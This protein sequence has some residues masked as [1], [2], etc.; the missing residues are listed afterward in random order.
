MPSAP[1]PSSG[2]VR[3]AKL[4]GIF[5][6]DVHHTRLAAR[7]TESVSSGWDALHRASPC[8]CSTTARAPARTSHVRSIRR[9]HS[10]PDN[11][12]RAQRFKALQPRE[13]SPVQGFKELRTVLPALCSF[14]I[15][16][17]ARR[18][19]PASLSP[20]PFLWAAP[21]SAPLLWPA[22]LDHL[23]GAGQVLCLM[24]VRPRPPP[25]LQAIDQKDQDRLPDHRSLRS[26][27]NSSQRS[28]NIP[29]ATCR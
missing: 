6:C 2:L 14:Q 25:L 3:W 19:L 28:S 17:R 13:R 16:S 10:C 26:V 11:A 8:T 9:G 4:P 7:H 22:S 27:T 5:S 20:S 1:R 23:S 18:G 29:S 24:A 15:W 12:A 21:R